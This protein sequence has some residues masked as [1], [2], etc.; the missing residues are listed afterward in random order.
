MHAMISGK[1]SAWTF[2]KCL[3]LRMTELYG[4]QRLA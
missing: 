4:Q 2:D 3:R 1:S